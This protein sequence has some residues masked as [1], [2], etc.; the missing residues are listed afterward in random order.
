MRDWAQL[1]DD[2]QTK[3]RG[4]P[5]G[6][7]GQGVEVGGATAEWQ[8]HTPDGEWPREAA[9]GGLSTLGSRRGAGEG[10]LIAGSRGGQTRR[11]RWALE[12]QMHATSRVA[13]LYRA[14]KPCEYGDE[15]S[16]LPITSSARRSDQRWLTG[17]W[18]SAEGVRVE[19]DLMR[20][21]RRDL[22]RNKYGVAQD[23]SG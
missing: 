14:A 17:F 4:A 19:W 3:G 8:P 11:E 12:L 23:R 2:V 5:S 9:G 22:V 1:A 16:A 21:K 18:T 20:W 13:N 10:P 6:E 15:V 7:A